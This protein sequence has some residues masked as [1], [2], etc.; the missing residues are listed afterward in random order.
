MERNGL[1]IY[2]LTTLNGRKAFQARAL[3]A[4]NPKLIDYLIATRPH[5]TKP[6]STSQTPARGVSPSKDNIRKDVSIV[7]ENRELVKILNGCIQRIL[8]LK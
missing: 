2:K 8:K 4:H 6:L 3:L 5:D 1:I 7:E